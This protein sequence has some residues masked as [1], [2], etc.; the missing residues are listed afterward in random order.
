[1]A[2]APAPAPS[3]SPTL[4]NDWGVSTSYAKQSS[5]QSDLVVVLAAMICAFI[6]A[7]G[8]NSALSCAIRCS[9]RM[10]MDHS[11]IET[12]RLANTGVKKAAMEAIPIIV[13]TSVSTLP[14]GLGIDCSICLAEFREE[15]KLRVLP[16]CNHGFHMECIDKWLVSHSSCPI[17]RHSLNPRRPSGAQPTQSRCNAARVVIDTT[18]SGQAMLT[19]T[20]TLEIIARE[21]T[22]VATVSPLSENQSA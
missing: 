20:E 19:G 10:G 17:C 8:L 6:C 1:L 22:E 11:D 21:A 15:E 5:L 12:M 2:S 13:Y 16:Q 7:V 3:P 18:D 9:R 4:Y 14:P